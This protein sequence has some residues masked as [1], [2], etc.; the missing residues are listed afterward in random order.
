VT[1]SGAAGG[2]GGFKRG[3]SGAGKLRCVC[4][5]AAP[6]FARR[7]SARSHASYRPPPPAAPQDVYRRL[8]GQR[9]SAGLLRIRTSQGFK[10][11]RFY[12]RLFADRQYDNLHHI[13]ACD[14]SDTFVVSAG[15]RITRGGRGMAALSRRGTREGQNG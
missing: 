10:P 5:D 9:A 8:S 2:V 12:G 1:S 7:C 4:L 15:A 13:I 11:C 3:E 6:V 14:A